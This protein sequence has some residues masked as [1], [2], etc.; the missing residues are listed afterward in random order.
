MRLANTCL[1][2]P[3]LCKVPTWTRNNREKTVP[4]T[5]DGKK[6][7]KLEPDAM[8]AP[9]KRCGQKHKMLT[10]G[11]YA[12]CFHKKETEPTNCFLM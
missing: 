5:E 9:I 12:Q 10:M 7:W 8:S 2:V 11:P 3:I 6:L 4:E 1:F